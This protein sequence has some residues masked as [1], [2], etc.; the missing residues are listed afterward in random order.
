MD[1]FRREIEQSVSVVKH[2]ERADALDSL[3]KVKSDLGPFRRA[4]DGQERVGGG[5][6]GGEARADDKHASAKSTKRL[7]NTGRPEQEAADG[8]HGEPRHKGDSEA[9]PPQDPSR[10]GGGADEVGAEVG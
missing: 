6:E 10:D 9:V 3:R 4:A 5:L 8:E 1:I 2:T 7:F